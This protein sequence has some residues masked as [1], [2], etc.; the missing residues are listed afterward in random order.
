MSEILG[1]R[2]R[3]A[4]GYA[5]LA[6]YEGW[7]ELQELPPLWGWLVNGLEFVV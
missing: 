4:R 7:T 1:F 2:I 6:S 5:V 3:A